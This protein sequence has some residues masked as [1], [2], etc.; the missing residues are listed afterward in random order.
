MAMSNGTT[1]AVVVVCVLGGAGFFAALLYYCICCRGDESGSSD[2]VTREEVQDQDT[3]S[4]RG[5]E[6]FGDQ[7]DD[8]TGPDKGDGRR[9]V[10]FVGDSER[11]PSQ[12]EAEALRSVLR[13]KSQSMSRS[14][15]RR[16]PSSEKQRALP[17][18]S[19]PRGLPPVPRASSSPAPRAPSPVGREGFLSPRPPLGQAAP[20]APTTR[21]RLSPRAPDRP[22]LAGELLV[23]AEGQISPRRGEGI[24]SPGPED[25]VWYDGPLETTGYLPTQGYMEKQSVDSQSTDPIWE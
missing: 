23:P 12:L 3:Q 9:R 21:I 7:E 4:Q 13:V 2:P 20:V 19:A 10:R 11:S 8:A 14:P 24:V 5:C 1:V 17:S 16:S 18:T 25:D 22:G 15:R 6:P